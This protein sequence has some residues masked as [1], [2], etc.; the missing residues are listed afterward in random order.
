MHL[1]P[2]HC[3]LTSK[4]QYS[5]GVGLR[6]YD[7]EGMG[8]QGNRELLPPLGRHEYTAE[9]TCKQWELNRGL[10]NEQAGGAM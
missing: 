3:F 6:P 1:G 4:M 8:E 9:V 7:L 5:P 2:S 10:E